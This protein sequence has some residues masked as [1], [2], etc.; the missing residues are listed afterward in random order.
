MKPLQRIDARQCDSHLI[1]QDEIGLNFQH[2]LY[3]GLKIMD[4]R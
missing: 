3:F 2:I 4:I 1:Q